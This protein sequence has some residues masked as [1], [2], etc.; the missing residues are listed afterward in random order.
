MTDLRVVLIN[1]PNPKNFIADRDAAGGFGVLRSKDQ[2]GFPP[3]SLLYSAAVLE[4][5]NFSVGLMDCNILNSD[6]KAAIEFCDRLNPD[7]VG[8]L[9]CTQ[10]FDQDCKFLKLLKE[11]VKVATV[12]AI[13][14]VLKFFQ[15][16]F[17]QLSNAD[18]GIFGEPEGIL[19]CVM[20]RIRD[21]EDLT[22][23]KGI[24]FRRNG[25]IVSTG[26]AA[27]I[28]NLEAL[29]Y[30]AWHLLPQPVKYSFTISSS[31]GC[32]YGCFY[33]PYVVSQGRQYRYR[34]PKSVVD[35]MLYLEKR[36]N[37]KL[38]QF[39]DPIFTFLKERVRGICSMILEEGVNVDWIIETRPEYLD[40]ELLELLA[41]AGCHKI[42]FG[43]ESGSK[44][45]LKKM[46]RLLPNFSA[47][48]YLTHV[49]AI[50]KKTKSVGIIPFALFMLGLPDEDWNSA[51][52]TINFAK[53]LETATQFSVLS[54]YPGTSFYDMARNEGLVVEDDFS[55]MTTYTNAVIRTKHLTSQ[56][57]DKLV[58]MANREV[59]AES[60]LRAI[61]RGDFKNV[62]KHFGHF[63][64]SRE[65][66]SFVRND[67]YV[68]VE[69][70]RQNSSKTKTASIQDNYGGTTQ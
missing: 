63:L 24:V 7:V 41:K 35:E 19:P 58:N 8:I 3:L 53:E 44:R 31:R 16:R 20:R 46:G 61:S 45:I 11:R 36:F 69:F 59:W 65:K 5:N 40:S 47:E 62:A 1:P 17:F 27:L 15:E 10:T 51:I 42:V 66:M 54:P 52:D 70:L 50:A 30:P 39:R 13:G 34:N 43:V 28:Q 18:V 56:E 67:L 22:P 26:E 14:P 4:K 64:G 12:A 6:E 48:A 32:P 23:I 29:P 55:K 2:Q 9:T 33:C 60:G 21:G 25:E 38:I 57:L 49:K 37:A 68:L